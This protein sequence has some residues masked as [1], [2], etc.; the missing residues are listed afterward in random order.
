MSLIDARATAERAAAALL[1]AIEKF[2]PR[3]SARLQRIAT[4][5]ATKDGRIE[6]TPENLSAVVELVQA[7]RGQFLDDELI[8][9]IADYIEAFNVI[10]QEV[11][12]AFSD[13]D[14]MDPAMIEA[15]DRTYK[16]QTAAILTSPETYNAGM[17][18]SLF[19]GLVTAVAIG[20]TLEEALGTVE[21]VVQSDALTADTQTLVESAPLLMQRAATAQAGQA[22]N[23]QF[24]L[25]QG[26]PI[27][28]TR[29][30][31]REREGHYF[32]VEEIRQWGRDGA[33]GV[34]LTGEGE[35]GW[36]GMVEGTD[37]NTIFI[38]LGGWYGER[39]SC[40]HVL[41]PVTL[42]RVPEEDRERMRRKGLIS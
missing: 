38:H 2:K 11:V 17:F 16:E 35:P 22:V 14:G 31:C 27:K 32:H 4:G 36:N 41:I 5:L 21:L 26:R 30:F 39:N 19:N 18:Q 23:V 8:D 42:G 28:T 40:R 34:D 1:A 37:E 13:F 12:N 29:L 7:M 9:A 15:I 6:S 24:Y 25:Y 20:S 3:L 10:G 33:E